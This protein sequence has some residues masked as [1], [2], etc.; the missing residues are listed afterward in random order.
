MVDDLFRGSHPAGAELADLA[1]RRARQSCEFFP[2]PANIRGQI[3][4]KL[5]WVVED[6]NRAKREEQL[7]LPAPKREPL[8][9]EQ[10][11]AHEA[12]MAAFWREWG[13]RPKSR[14]GFQGMRPH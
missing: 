11:C 6:F 14:P 2:T 12:K 9:P 3:A 7:F 5:A 4:D 13:E 10:F 1:L 8:T